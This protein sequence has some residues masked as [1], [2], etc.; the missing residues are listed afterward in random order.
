M[1]RLTITQSLFYTRV[2]RMFHR[3][4]P[5]GYDLFSIRET[6]NNQ[7][8]VIDAPDLTMSNFPIFSLAVF[9]FTSCTKLFALNAIQLGTRTFFNVPRFKFKEIIPPSF[10][11]VLYSERFEYFVVVFRLRYYSNGILNAT[12]SGSIQRSSNFR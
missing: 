4:R 10:G 7:R 12:D 6:S 5:F 2:A 9:F 8:K 11:Y 3:S 1:R